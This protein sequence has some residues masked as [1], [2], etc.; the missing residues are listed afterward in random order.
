[1]RNMCCTDHA[2]HHT[3]CNTCHAQY[4]PPC[5]PERAS[6]QHAPIAST[7]HPALSRT[8]GRRG[9]ASG[10][11][12]SPTPV[13]E[14]TEDLTTAPLHANTRPAPGAAGGQAPEPT[15]PQ[16]Q[17]QP[18]GPAT[19]PTAHAPSNQRPLP[20]PWENDAEAEALLS[21]LRLLPKAATQSTARWIPRRLHQQTGAALHTVLLAATALPTEGAWSPRAECA[22]LLL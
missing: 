12:I 14:G 19:T 3:C 21:R 16:A 6:R 18:H 8:A 1:M 17:P 20:L 4:C 11:N 13:I 5:L 22:N 15:C 9:Q 2:P 7:A 10:A